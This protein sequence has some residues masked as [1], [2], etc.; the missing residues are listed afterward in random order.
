STKTAHF[1]RA[2]VSYTVTFNGAASGFP[3]P[4]YQCAALIVDSTN[5]VAF[6]KNNLLPIA[7][8]LT[9]TGDVDIGSAG[10]D[11]ATLNTSFLVS[12]A[13]SSIGTVADVGT[14]NV[15]G[16][17]FN[18][19]GSGN[20]LEIGNDLGTGTLNISGGGRV[21][22]TSATGDASLG[23]VAGTTLV[24]FAGNGTV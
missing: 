17:T 19:T 16:G 4:Q 20:V 22:L 24:H 12:C 18:I 13:A 5:N 9:V 3:P 11:N 1:G 21:N 6:A 15:N 10:N 14:L 2:G 8:N 7:P 23:E